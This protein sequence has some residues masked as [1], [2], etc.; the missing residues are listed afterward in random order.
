M[1][2]A[3]HDA[4]RRGLADDAIGIAALLATGSAD[5]NAA[6]RFGC[7]ALHCAAIRGDRSIKA[8]Q[9][10]LD[11]G[12]RVDTI[13]PRGATALHYAAAN[14][15][16]KIVAVLLSAR[17]NASATDIDGQTPLHLA[18]AKNLLDMVKILV[19]ADD[20]IPKWCPKADHTIEDHRGKSALDYALRRQAKAEQ[21]GEKAIVKL[22]KQLPPPKRVPSYARGATKCSIA[23]V[24]EPSEEPAKKPLAGAERRQAAP[25]RN[26]RL[27]CCCIS[28]RLVRR[29]HGL[30]VSSRC[31][32]VPRDNRT[33]PRSRG[34]VCCQITAGEN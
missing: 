32:A 7:T 28:N 33:R 21:L 22:L 17:A 10:L 3:L 34:R 25:V 14:D 16:R 26:G 15:A 2:L 6:D 11:G 4:A 5:A 31:C 12:A 27:L 9:P 1:P 13:D 19:G 8:I 23:S 18:A 30:T 29:V 24:V 20:A